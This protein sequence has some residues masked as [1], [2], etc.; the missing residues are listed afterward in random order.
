VHFSE[1]LFVA[2]L[3]VHHTFSVK[4]ILQFSHRLDQNAIGISRDF[5]SAFLQGATSWRTTP[6][7]AVPVAGR[8]HLV[9]SGHSSCLL[10]RYS[11]GLD[12]SNPSFAGALDEGSGVHSG[13]CQELGRGRAHFCNRTI[14]QGLAREQLL[15]LKIE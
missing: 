9:H 11:T 1:V 13:G 3:C 7:L 12:L 15:V 8:A 10:F 14:Q 4:W 6:I 5:G 2:I